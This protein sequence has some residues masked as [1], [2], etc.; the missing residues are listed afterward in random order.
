[1]WA[2]QPGV[3]ALSPPPARD[4]YI[5]MWSATRHRYVIADRVMR[6]V[7]A[8]PDADGV[9]RVLVFMTDAVATAYLQGCYQVWGERP[10][11]GR[12]HPAPLPRER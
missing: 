10:K 7:C 9:C 3:S 2:T 5:T 6:D 11:M 1:M 4:R 12:R 8:L